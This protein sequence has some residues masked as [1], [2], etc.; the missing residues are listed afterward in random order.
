M[1]KTYKFPLIGEFSDW[2]YTALIMDEITFTK[3]N[4]SF[5]LIEGEAFEGVRKVGAAVSEDF[6]QVFGKPLTVISSASEFSSL[7]KAAT[8]STLVVAATLG[9]SQ[10][11]TSLI[12][13]RKFDDSVF[14]IKED[15]TSGGTTNRLLREVYSFSIISNPFSELPGIKNILLIAGSDKRGTIYGMFHL[16]E[17]LGVSPWT[18]WSEVHPVQK[19]IF[20]I[21]SKDNSV[22]KEPSV[23]LRGFFIND[24][25]PAFGQFAF[26]K[27]G[28]FNAK[29]YEQVF[30]L[31]LRLKGNYLWPAMWTS[32]FPLDGPGLADEELADCYGIVIGFSHH[33]PCLRASEEWDKV[34]GKDTPYGTAWD[35]H[36]NSEG[37]TNYWRDG[38]KR[39]G[40]FEHT[41]T[42]G[43]RG[44]RDSILMATATLQDNINTLKD[45]ITTQN[46]LIAEN[47]NSNLS[48]TRRVL[49]VYKEVETYFAGDAHTEGLKSWSGLDGITCMLCED[50]YGNMRM[51]PEADQE[52]RNGGWGMYYHFDYHGAPVSY[53]W[54]NS[55]SLVKTNEQM[56]RAYEHG[57]KKIWIVNVGDIVGNE[58]PLS[59]FI[60]LAYD[61]EK[62]RSPHAAES[63]I[64]KWVAQNFGEQLDCS[65]QLATCTEIL[66]GSIKLNSQRKNEALN[67]GIYH[68]CNFHEAE[69]MYDTADALCKKADDLLE[70]IPFS[71]RDSFI[72]LVYYPCVAELNLVKMHTA[73]SRNALFASQGSLYANELADIVQS[74]IARD[75]ELKELF[76]KAAGGKWNHLADSAHT[77]FR[78]WNDEDWRWPVI[79]TVTP[80]AKSKMIVSF[81]NSSECTNGGFWN[82][83][84]I[85]VNDEL[86]NQNVNTISLD[87]SNGG[88]T[89]FKYSATSSATWLSFATDDNTSAGS[90]ASVAS[91]ASSPAS[92]AASAASGASSP[93]SSA[94]SSTS[95][96]SSSASGTV[97]T[98]TRIFIT[99]D[100]SKFTGTQTTEVQV[101]GSFGNEAPVC[102]KLSIIADSTDRSSLPKGTYVESQQFVSI[103]ATKAP[104]GKATFTFVITDASPSAYTARLYLEPAN[105]A[106][107]NDTLSYRV[108][109][110][111]VQGE[112]RS[113]IP[114]KYATDSSCSDWSQAVLANRRIVEYPITVQQG[115]NTLTFVP[116]SEGAVLK[117]AVLFA[118]ST[119]PAPSY[120]PPP[121]S[122][123]LR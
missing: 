84:K 58:L 116:L 56:V 81:S 79:H 75:G 7:N 52:E 24:E 5:L 83:R 109:V 62:Y 10:L 41:I 110:N 114:Q 39:S 107:L 118:S 71:C 60:D 88:A 117:H 49:A 35:F 95:C 16:S 78:T 69:R 72:A 48:K 102:A 40:K 30:L 94:V 55:S 111:N 1:Y 9:K 80:I 53:E 13:T 12:N 59:Y 8:G 65:T 113:S 27:F 50:N 99:V 21:T 106:S 44:E 64:A 119:P 25:W 96:P 91:G 3:K 93:A 34:K 29:L 43:M 74:C 101:T 105:P 70:E 26:E 45:I 32:S 92:S 37:L 47:V 23:E 57:I 123:H 112:A 31:L 14:Y 15:S 46:K 28:G 4:S 51:L 61:F 22:S 36:T 76:Y 66:T 18:W 38:L 108:D 73:A 82:G 122:Y 115:M 19:S 89:P 6:A 120:L 54:M 77:G 85:L 97:V 100:R 42:V 68:P 33:E 87:V 2:A 17:L 20:S 86:T 103:D 67:E 104:C 63:Y 121:E 90:T 11:L 98:H